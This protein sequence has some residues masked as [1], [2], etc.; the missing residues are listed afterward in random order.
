MK[1]ACAAFEIGK[2]AARSGPL[3]RQILRHTP[4][5]TVFVAGVLVSLFAASGIN[6]LMGAVLASLMLPIASIDARSFIIPNELTAAGFVA[7][8]IHEALVGGESIVT[9]V[10]LA[11]MRAAAV[12][13]IFWA[14]CVIYRRLRRREGLGLGD[15][16]LAGV[17]GAWLG[18]TTI[19]LAI[20]VAALSG[21]ATY[22]IRQWFLKR[23]IR[24]ADRLPFGAF[25]APAIWFGWLFEVMTA[26]HSQ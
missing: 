1:L 14:F 3:C 19:P 8:L 13:A 26:G 23:Q 20:E 24:V 12:A 6:G 10:A 15:V 4:V 22:L 16:K 21:L 25:L 18:V 5:A 9:S 11:T 2:Y 7:G 17:A